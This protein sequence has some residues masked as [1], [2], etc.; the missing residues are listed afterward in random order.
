VNV[1]ARWLA[2]ACWAALSPCCLAQSATDLLT[3]GNDR[4]VRREFDDARPL[5]ERALVLAREEQS[6]VG[7]GKAHHGLAKVFIGKAQYPAARQE[8]EEAR[9]ALE[10]SSAHAN[11]ARVYK[12]IGYVAWMQGDKPASADFFRRAL[13]EFESLGNEPHERVSTLYSLALALPPGDEKQALTRQGVELARA[14]PNRRVEG[15]L[16]QMWG[17]NLVDQGDYAAA[18]EKFDGSVA[19]LQAEEARGEEPWAGVARAALASVY[20][21]LG[22]VFRYHDHPE[23]SLDYYRRALAIHEQR[24]DRQ[25]I[26]TTTD[27]IGIVYQDTGDMPAAFEQYSKALTMA[28]ATGSAGMVGRQ[29]THL[30]SA[31]ISV[32][33]Y[34]K[35]LDLLEEA[36]RLAPLTSRG[37]QD[38]SS[39][40]LGLNRPDDAL[41][42]AERAVTAAKPGSGPEA[43]AGALERRARAKVALGR[44]AEAQ[45]DADEALV[46]LER[47][48]ARMI[49]TDFMKSGFGSEHRFV[50][51]TLIDV[52]VRL[53][54]PERALE[55][56]ERGRARAFLD[57]LA[58]RELEPRRAA[59]AADLEALRDIERDLVDKGVDPATEAAATAPIVRSGDAETAALWQKWQS[60]APDLKSL[61]SVPPFTATQAAAA[62]KRLDSTIVAYWVSARDTYAWV[63]SPGGSIRV[64]RIDAGSDRLKGLVLQ[65]SQSGGAGTP[66]AGREGAAIDAG[67][68]S[69]EPWRQLYDALILPIRQWLPTAPGSR[70][71]IVPHGPLFPVSFAGLL[72]ERGNYLVERYALHSVPAAAVLDFT[73]RRKKDTAGKPPRYLLVADPASQP[74][75]PDGKPLPRLPGSRR[76]VNDIA[77][78]APAGSATILVGDAALEERIRT[79][80]SDKT[81]LHFATHAVV[82]DDQPFESFLALAGDGRLT[83]QKIYGLDLSANLVVLSGCRT[84]LGKVTGDGIVGLTRA[85]F[86]AGTPSVVATMWEVADDPTYLVVTEFY[87]A[88]RRTGDKALALREAQLRLLRALRRG[89]VKVKTA[90][91]QLTL[92]EHPVFWAAFVLLGEP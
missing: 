88:L 56:A 77:R 59:G 81:V 72:D 85:F 89:E 7:E 52:T 38:L 67:A 10:T 17:D 71:T 20:V 64:A 6:K 32:G 83:A 30:A 29:L 48:R 26:I 54:Q 79:L 86:Y 61:V 36:A 13:G 45:A 82:R 16:L 49:P 46:L 18:V 78:Q 75:L 40:Y 50:F 92:P 34:Q 39:A 73:E 41:A 57:L 69:R 87:K 66:L 74:A 80:S 43:R 90:V 19:A 27:A 37:L 51:S 25:G 28:R 55:V 60:A 9:V 84:G 21:S 23:R 22:R 4:L 63:V 44:L 15:A 76:E 58:T 35:A 11:L 2:L 1:R 5:F 14:L 24:G 70:L 31:H 3:Q 65:A 42:A 53:G 12:D 33:D 68:Q 8:L 91:G 62:A 47:L